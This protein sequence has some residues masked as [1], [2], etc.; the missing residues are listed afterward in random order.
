MLYRSAS[1]VLFLS[2]KL[3]KLVNYFDN[4]FVKSSRL[5]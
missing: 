2:H 1:V 4:F 5:A 3:Y